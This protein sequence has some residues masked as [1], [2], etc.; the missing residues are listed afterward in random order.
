MVGLFDGLVLG[1]VD[2]FWGCFDLGFVFWVVWCFRF[3]VLP[4]SL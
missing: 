3:V 1:F 4:V 2:L